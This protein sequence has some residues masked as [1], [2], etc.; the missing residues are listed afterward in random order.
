MTIKLRKTRQKEA[1]PALL[2]I[3]A[4][5]LGTEYRKVAETA[6]FYKRLIVDKRIAD[7]IRECNSIL[8][9]GGVFKDGCLYRESGLAAFWSTSKDQIVVCDHAVP[10]SELVRQ[11]IEGISTIEEQIF[12]PVVRITKESND[13]L[14]RSGFAKKGFIEG[15]PLF[16][17]SHIGMKITTHQG[18]EVDPSKWTDADHWKLVA[19]T[20]EL[21]PVLQALHIVNHKSV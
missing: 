15:Y 13:K 11:N 1:T 19:E 17:Y 2:V 12:S 8:G 7:T 21:K 14:T 3:E 16:R 4:I 20:E 18:Y 5:R 9:M 6:R 10:V